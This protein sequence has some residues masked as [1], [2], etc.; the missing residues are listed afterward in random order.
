[1]EYNRKITT[2]ALAMI[3]IIAVANLRGIPFSAKL[4]TNVL[5]YYAIAAI[6]FYIPTALITAE[7]AT[8]WPNRGGIYVWV[9]EAF[10]EFSGFLTIWLQWIYN[11]VWYPTILTFVA[12]NVATII[13]PQ[14]AHNAVYTWSVIT[15]LFWLCT[16]LNYHGLKFSSAISTIG[17]IL[18]TVVPMM[19]I[20]ILGGLWYMQHGSPHLVTPAQTSTFGS[21]DHLT[22]FSFIV[23]A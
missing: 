1:M 17:T 8:A 21:M 3:N 19:M 13:D 14:L 9:R 10:G 2:T 6:A 22:F 5:Y 15:V 11:V 16:L 20:M 23:T 12:A 4:G 7:L 18:G